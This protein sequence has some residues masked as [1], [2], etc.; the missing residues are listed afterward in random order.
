MHEPRPFFDRVLALLPQSQR[1][2]VDRLSAACCFFLAYRKWSWCRFLGDDW[3]AGYE[4]EL[5][6]FGLPSLLD[7]GLDRCD[8]L[9]AITFQANNMWLSLAVNMDH[10][11][12]SVLRSL[13]NL[14]NVGPW[15][16]D[17]PS[18]LGDNQVVVSDLDR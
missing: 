17:R 5:L 7:L 12:R 4:G 14:A 15:E 3:D 10:E 1:L 16:L 9:G 6:G 8:L 18:S 11:K 2:E 13:S